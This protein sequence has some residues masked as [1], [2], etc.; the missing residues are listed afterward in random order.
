MVLL[1]TF[2]C[3]STSTDFCTVNAALAKP[4]LP[5]LNSATGSFKTSS[6]LSPKAPATAALASA[7]VFPLLITA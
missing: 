1:V 3:A 2:A 5:A 4:V 7:S 6:I